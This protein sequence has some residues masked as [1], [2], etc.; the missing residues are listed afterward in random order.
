MFP[1]IEAVPGDGPIPASSVF[2]LCYY[3]AEAMAAINPDA[4]V[5]TRA[6]E[7]WKEDSIWERVELPALTN[8]P[9]IKRIWQVDPRPA[10]MRGQDPNTCQWYEPVIIWDR[11]NGGVPW[12]GGFKCPVV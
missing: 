4:Y 9:N 6:D 2:E 10:S 7:P 1:D 5:F 8:N 12:N 11:N 3:E